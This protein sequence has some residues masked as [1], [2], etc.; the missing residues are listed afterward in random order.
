M[1]IRKGQF[2]PCQG[3]TRTDFEKPVTGVLSHDL[4]GTEGNEWMLPGNIPF[5]SYKTI[6][7]ISIFFVFICRCP[8]NNVTAHLTNL[9]SLSIEKKKKNFEITIEEMPIVKICK[10]LY[11]FIRIVMIRAVC[12]KS[13]FQKQF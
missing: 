13:N 8:N 7:Y 10:C 12:I 2:V 3:K 4:E 5:A 9:F 11:T 6:R 1:K